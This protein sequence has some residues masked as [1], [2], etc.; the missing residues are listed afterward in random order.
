MVSVA[1]AVVQPLA[2]VVESVDALVA[3]I[4]VP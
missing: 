3:D 1:D 2:V 4:A